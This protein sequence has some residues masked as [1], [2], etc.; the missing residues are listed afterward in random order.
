MPYL[1]AP[2]QPRAM[3]V[4]PNEGRGKIGGFILAGLLGLSGV[5]L[6]YP[7]FY[8]WFIWGLPILDPRVYA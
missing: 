6:Y 3:R 8:S 5:S 7:G 4:G 2:K 1:G